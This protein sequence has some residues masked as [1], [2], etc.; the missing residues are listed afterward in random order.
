MKKL[1]SLFL[2][3]LI[4][5]QSVIA[6]SAFGINKN[7]EIIVGKNLDW[8]CNIAYLVINKRN[9]TKEAFLS[10][11]NGVLEWTSK[12]GSITFNPNSVGVPSGGMNEMGLVIEESWL[13]PTQYPS[14]DE[15]PVIDEIQ[16]I[17]YQ[18][19]NCTKV[20]EVIESSSQLRIEKYYGKSHY[21][22]YD[23]FGNAASIDFVNGEMIYHI[24]HKTDVQVLTN[25]TY[26]LSL[27]SLKTF[28]EF[29]GTKLISQKPKSIY[30]FGRAAKMIKDY[31]KNDSTDIVDYG[32]SILKNI[33]QKSTTW[34]VIYDITNLKIC[35]KTSSSP[36]LKELSFNKFDFYCNSPM[37]LC[38]VNNFKK[39]DISD[40]FEEYT[41]DKNR[42]LVTRVIANWRKNNFALHIKDKDVE[43]LIQYPET[44]KCNE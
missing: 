34:S 14:Q 26:E 12:Y 6:C 38:D 5:K 23:R 29:G 18:L 7:N 2:L 8:F 11:K 42:D 43:K 33:S 3:T 36:E 21:F 40:Q 19:D 16:W 37:L 13:S 44:M 24:L 31:E 28:E 9:V 17:Q 15:R 41:L 32:F 1:V 10:S 20:E 4:I 27:D 35:Y 22:V 39:G 25:N 30:R